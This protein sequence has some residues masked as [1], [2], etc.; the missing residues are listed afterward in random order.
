MADRSLAGLTSHVHYTI[1]TIN[2]VLISLEKG[3]I[4]GAQTEM[5][6]E[7]SKTAYLGRPVLI[8]TKIHRTGS[9]V[10]LW[11]LWWQGDKAVIMQIFGVHLF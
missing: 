10:S 2:T 11:N 3:R 9:K 6:K 7:Y 4:K 8:Q 1:T 5:Q